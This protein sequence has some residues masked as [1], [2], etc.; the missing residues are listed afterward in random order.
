[1]SWSHPTVQVGLEHAQFVSLLE[2]GLRIDLG[3]SWRAGVV[4]EVDYLHGSKH[5]HS[6]SGH[7]GRGQ[8]VHRTSSRAIHDIVIGHAARVHTC[9]AE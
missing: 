8:L 3:R 4:V 2:V 7:V 1:M 9:A 5:Q 6:V